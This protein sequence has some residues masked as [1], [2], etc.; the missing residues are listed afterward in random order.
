MLVCVHLDL[1][2][3]VERKGGKDK[4]VE[5]ERL[6]VSVYRSLNLTFPSVLCATTPLMQCAFLINTS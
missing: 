4:G 3:F 1:Y 6:V 5:E 2:A